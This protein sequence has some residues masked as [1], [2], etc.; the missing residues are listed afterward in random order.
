MREQAR[1]AFYRSGIL[2][3]QTEGQKKQEKQT[4]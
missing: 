3:V 2:R 1:L 4:E